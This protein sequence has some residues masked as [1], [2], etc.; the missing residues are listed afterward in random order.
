M[1]DPQA[2]DPTRIGPYTNHGRLGAGGMGRVHLGRSPGGR[3]VA[4]PTAAAVPSTAGTRAMAAPPNSG[5]ETRRSLQ[6]ITFAVPVG[7]TA[8]Q[9]ADGPN[10]VCVLPPTALVGRPNDGCAVDGWRSACR[11]RPVTNGGGR[12]TSNPAPGGSGR[13]TRGAAAP[14]FTAAR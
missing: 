11:T 5:G 10:V 1:R 3:P 8:E 4:V 14:S 9:G 12:W 2:G 7:W 6:G 13:A